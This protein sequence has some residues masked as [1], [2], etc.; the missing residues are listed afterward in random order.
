MRHVAT[1]RF[2]FEYLQGQHGHFAEIKIE[3]P[4]DSEMAD[5]VPPTDSQVEAAVEREWK[6]NGYR[7]GRFL[8]V[9]STEIEY[10]ATA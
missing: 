4:Y 9:V 7:F 1:F 3:V 5:P 8:S 2:E 10:D 6:K